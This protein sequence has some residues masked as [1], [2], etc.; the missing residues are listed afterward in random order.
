MQ[1]VIVCLF[2]VESEGYQAITELRNT[3]GNDTSLVSQAVLI[4][5]ENGALKVLDSF[6]TGANTTDDTAIGGLI[7]MCVGV[8]GGPI[9]M[10]LEAG[11]GSLAG[12]TLDAADAADEASLIEQIA[13]KL[14]DGVALIG[15]SY[16]EDESVLD[17]KLSA[18]KTVIARF[19]AAVVAQEVEAAREMQ[20]E[21]SRQAK[22]DLRKQRKEDFKEKIEEKRNNLKS[23]FDSVK[24]K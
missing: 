15:L 14:D 10:L 3:P 7:G 23:H 1:N 17:N 21:M 8:L 13:D 2:D 5:K 18:Y 16:E 20:I 24:S 11:W 19:D 6:D 4:K 12:M 9:G 22:A